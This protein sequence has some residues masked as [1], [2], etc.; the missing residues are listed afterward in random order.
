MGKVAGKKR[1]KQDID[2]L[3]QDIQRRLDA[4]KG[5]LGFALKVSD[6]SL[7]E[8]EWLYFVVIPDGSGVRAYDYAHALTEVEDEMR[9]AGGDRHILLV[10]ALPD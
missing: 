8:A 2:D 10:P 1:T 3:R 7:Q 9:K 5:K 4:R 6:E